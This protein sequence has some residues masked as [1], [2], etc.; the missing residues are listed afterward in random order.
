PGD[1]ADRPTPAEVDAARHKLA[2]WQ[3]ARENSYAWR[4]FE[5]VRRPPVPKVD[6]PGWH[7]NPVDAFLAAEH[8]RRGLRPRP[9][10][11]RHVLLRRVYLDLIGLP[12]T[13]EEVQAFLADRS[14]DAY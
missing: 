5:P 11:P 3:A 6:R 2:A 1:P 12:P 9:E 8:Q 10:A 7:R 14:P 4:P 13:P